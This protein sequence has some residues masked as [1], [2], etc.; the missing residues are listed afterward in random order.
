MRFFGKKKEP[1]KAP[2]LEEAN[3]GM[4]TRITALKEKVQECDKEL[5]QLREA[6]KNS[7]GSTQ[8]TNKQRAVQLLKRRKM[9]SSQ[10]E[11][12]IGTQFNVE[13]MTFAA[14]NIQDT[15]TTVAA[16]KEAHKVQSQQLKSFKINDIENMMDD[17]ADMMLD[18]EE[19]NEVMSRNYGC[20]IDEGEL[21][22]ELEELDDADY[23][24]DLNRDS[25]SAPSYLPAPAEK[26]AE[27]HMN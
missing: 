9:Y 1:V 4:E 20:E 21:E 26:N 2:T 22:R 18:T 3:S 7:R 24:D 14:Q 16:M 23:L 12:L 8:A 15:L 6:I 25:L 11:G 27:I 5:A 10:L 13:Q 19:I 17:M